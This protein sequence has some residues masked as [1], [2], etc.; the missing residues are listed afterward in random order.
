[1]SSA[2]ALVKAASRLVQNQTYIQMIASL[3]LK[4]VD[5]DS[6]TS[7]AKEIVCSHSFSQKQYMC[8]RN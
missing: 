6:L 3:F 4:Y 8:M 7:V 2:M 1:M 5:Q